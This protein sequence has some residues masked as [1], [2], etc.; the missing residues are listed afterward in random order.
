MK[1]IVVALFLVG[2]INAA[3]AQNA[4]DLNAPAKQE[5]AESTGG[6][7]EMTF[8][9]DVHN[10]DTLEYGGNG[11]YDFKFKNTGTEPVI[12]T[13]AK[14]SCGCTVPTYPK[15]VPIK[16]GETQAIKVTYDTKRAGTFLK[17]VTIY[18]NA[19]EPV[20]QITIKGYV[21]KKSTEPTFSID[22]KKQDGFIPLEKH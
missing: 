18:S 16:P 10:F 20:K 22:G 11:S 21:N 1:K 13:E 5:G 3:N 4:V 19:K 6:K 12:I 7:G 15:D 14:G 2:V 8:E 17:T 9:K